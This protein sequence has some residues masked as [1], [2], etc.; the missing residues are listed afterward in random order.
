MFHPNQIDQFGGLV[1]WT[2]SSTRRREQPFTKTA[3]TS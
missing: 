2:G 3:G 1:R